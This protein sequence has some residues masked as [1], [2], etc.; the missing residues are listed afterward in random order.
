MLCCTSVATQADPPLHLCCSMCMQ[1]L[2]VRLLQNPTTCSS[3][4]CAAVV[5]LCSAACGMLLH[6]A[7]LAEGLWSAEV[8]RRLACNPFLS[9]GGGPRV[10]LPLGIFQVVH[11][12]G[13]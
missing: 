13:L 10:Q 9:T 3:C 12:C 8:R 4:S 5:C 7:P 6:H 1:P 2:L 11:P